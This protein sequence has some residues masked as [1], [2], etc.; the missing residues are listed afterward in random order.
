MMPDTTL[1][2]RLHFPFASFTFHLQAQEQIELPEYKGSAF[3]GGFGHVMKK[4]CC[5][6]PPGQCTER[7]QLGNNCAYAYIFE[8]PQ[9][10]AASETRPIEA[11][12]LPHPFV[13]LPPLSRREN[14]A[15]GEALSFGLTLIGRSIEFLP[16][17]IYAF[18]ELGRTGIGRGRGRYQ[19]EHVLETSTNSE[20]YSRLTKKMAGNI[21]VRDLADLSE[22]VKAQD[23]HRARLEFISPTRILDQNRLVSTLPFDLLMR[24]LLR[25][26]S[27][28]AR[29]HCGD[30]WNLDYGAVLQAAHATV[31]VVES[32]LV[33]QDWERYSNRQQRRMKLGGFIGSVCYAGEL[34]PFLPLLSLGQYIHLGKNTTF[35]M[36]KYVLS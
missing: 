34:G 25:R 7:C 6:L 12:N 17:F 11:T 20:I 33:W 4:V 30:E 15:P 3:R 28:L 36:G 32:N 13:I 18:D 22:A 16:Y 5:V 31:H 29:I 27:L 26:A 14:I 35:G 19:L 24:G 2:S 23:Q 1:L 9:T 8:T 21:S 10:G